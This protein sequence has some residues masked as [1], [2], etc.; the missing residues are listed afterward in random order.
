MSNDSHRKNVSGPWNVLLVTDSL[1]DQRQLPALLVKN[2]HQVTLAT[3]CHEA[4]SFCENSRMD[5]VILD[6][7]LGEANSEQLIRGIRQ[8]ESRLGQTPVPIIALDD[9]GTCSDRHL[10]AGA[11]ACL[12]R[13]LQLA[14]FQDC[15]LAYRQEKPRGG[16][17]NPTSSD[18]IDWKIALDAVGGRRD[19]L[20]ELLEIFNEEYSATLVQIR[21]AIQDQD[22]KRLQMSA[23][24]LK[25]CLR[26][27]GPTTA[28]SLSGEL[29]D[30]G[31]SN[32][33]EGASSLVQPLTE[34]LERLAPQIRRG[35]DSN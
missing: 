25:G 35:P 3:N 18:E 19:L 10:L 13:P 4:L 5:A 9:D 7:T 33:M 22:A 31:R 16:I 2:R 26:Y 11:T 23:H 1:I 29:E 20:A 15:V 28:A 27:F 12:T 14:E 21:G 32:Q 30:M 17:H 8:L 24:Q 6:A 34:A